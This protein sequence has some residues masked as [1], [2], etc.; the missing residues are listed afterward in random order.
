MSPPL[1]PAVHERERLGHNYISQGRFIK[2]SVDKLKGQV[3][4]QSDL[5]T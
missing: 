5:H 2:Q 4:L 1:Q 3:H